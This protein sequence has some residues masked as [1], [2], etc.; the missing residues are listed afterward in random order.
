MNGTRGPCPP[1]ARPVKMSTHV[2]YC[3]VGTV[4][5]GESR[6]RAP[7]RERLLPAPVVECVVARHQAVEAARA[8]R[9]SGS[10]PAAAAATTATGVGALFPIEI[11][12]ERIIVLWFRFE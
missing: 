11:V 1:A 10:D 4:A 6:I 9:D 5:L 8:L 7:S 3:E 12:V 2:A